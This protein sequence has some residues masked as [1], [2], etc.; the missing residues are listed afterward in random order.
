MPDE[1]SLIPE[2]TDEDI[3]WV[4]GLMRLDA[5]D[6]PRRAFLTKGTTVDVAACPGSGKTTLI[7][8]KL[9][10]WRESGLIDRRAFVSCLTLTWHARKLSDASEVPSWDSDC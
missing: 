5:L 9:A 7:V 6:Q 1:S 8:A 10:I 3:D 2:V 4:R